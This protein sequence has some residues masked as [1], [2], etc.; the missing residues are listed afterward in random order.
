MAD[1]IFLDNHTKTRPSKELIEQMAQDLHEHWLIASTGRIKNKM[2][3]LL[4]ELEGSFHLAASGASANFQV[5][6]SHYMDSIR[7]TG[8]THILSLE[9]EQSS[10]LEGIQRLEKFEVQGKILPVNSQGQ[11]TP[12]ALQEALRARS[13]LLS[14]SFAHPLTGVIQPIHDLSAVC[15]EHD[16]RLHVDVGCAVGKRYLMGID[17]DFITFDGALLHCPGQVGGILAKED[18]A[19]FAFGGEDLPY[20]SL[21]T[22]ARA[23]ELSYEKT[24]HYAMEI[25]R[26]R[27][28]LET[29]CLA[30]GGKVFFQEVERLANCAVIAFEGIHSERLQVL[31]KQQGIFAT[32]GNGRLAEVLKSC[33][34]DADLAHA[35]VSFVLSDE[36]T[37]KEIDQLVAVFEEKLDTLRVPS[38]LFIEEDAKAKGMRVCQAEMLGDGK[39]LTL[40]LLIDEE[41]GVIADCKYA[42]FGP[43]SLLETADAAAALLLR[44][45][46]MQ[47]KRLSA[48]LIEQKLS[49][50]TAHLNFLID[51]IDAATESCMDI[52]IEDVYV[53]PPEMEGGER[54]VYPGWEELSDSQKKAVI[55]EVVE[56]EIRPYVELD[57]GGVEVLKV[58]DNRVLIA[59]SGN[60]TS[61]FSAT[62][63]TL[64]A[65][66]NILRHKIYP[67]LMVIPDES[68]LQ[69]Q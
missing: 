15:R 2:G 3:S 41:D 43:P 54:Q 30:L 27:D 6:L 9:T 52:P 51:A 65:I 11:L 37:Q 34:V 18:V 67:D 13:S 5:L 17:A 25:G 33:Q 38:V 36:T 32:T 55:D 10:I 1:W 58:E 22:L 69:N 24:D 59:Y 29:K 12:S 44:K 19:P 50:E 61:C 28:L 47:A 39:S 23:L 14:I 21:S 35:A 56:K 62:G 48:D 8:R 7:E 68:F 20:A 45:N 40:A 66:G 63:A 42:A 16:V 57:A 60:C 4:G 26:L 64:D 31:L 53:A 46:Y 49:K